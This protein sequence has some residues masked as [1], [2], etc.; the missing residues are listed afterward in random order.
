MADVAVFGLAGA[1]HVRAVLLCAA[2]GQGGAGAGRCAQFDDRPRHRCVHQHRHGEA[3]FTLAARGPICP[4]RDAGIHAHRLRANAF[5]HGLRGR[6]SNLERVV[7]CRHHRHR[8]VVVGA[9][10]G[11]RR[12]GCSGH[13]HGVSPE[14]HFALGDVG[15]VQPVRA[16]W[17]RARRHADLVAHTRGGRCTG[18]ERAG[19][20]A[21]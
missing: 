8:L 2:L 18:C 15:N 4:Q 12:C 10:F 7:D 6:Q 9:G 16:H 5:G 21:G 17:H 3:V 1:V 13:R 19:G 20:Q 11:G 14:R